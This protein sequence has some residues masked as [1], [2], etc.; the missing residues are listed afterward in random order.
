MEQRKSLKSAPGVHRRPVACQDG[1][2]RHRRQRKYIYT[3]RR[4]SRQKGRL[5]IRPVDLLL[6]R[7]VSFGRQPPP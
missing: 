4:H 7:Q 1:S 3:G 2:L 5:Y 6:I